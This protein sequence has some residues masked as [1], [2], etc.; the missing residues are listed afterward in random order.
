MVT[1]DDGTSNVTLGI[2][3]A[4]STTAYGELPWRKHSWVPTGGVNGTGAINMHWSTGMGIG[5]S[6]VWITVPR[7]QHFKLRYV[8]KQTAPM[9]HA[10]SA[11]K[12]LRMCTTVGCGGGSRIGTLES[13][14][15]QF[16]FYWDDYETGAATNLGAAVPT[17]S[18]WHVYELEL[19]YRTTS[20]TV[21]FWLDGLY[22]RQDTA[23]RSMAFPAGSSM[24]MSPFA[25]M[26]SCGN[27]GCQAT[28]NTGDYTVDDF[29]FTALP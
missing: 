11:I 23:P 20:P 15:G 3:L 24:V 29:S 6:P 12:L 9:Q 19:D 13:K 26:Y 10:G 17:D 4:G 8:V 21:T 27:T 5:F 22:I 18:Q 25:E 2:N 7:A 14:Q 1:F 16:V 28:I